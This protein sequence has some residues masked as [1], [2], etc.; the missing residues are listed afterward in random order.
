[1]STETETVQN[2]VENTVTVRPPVSLTPESSSSS[3]T[4]ELSVRA[5]TF[6]SPLSWT[7]ALF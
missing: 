6:I 2:T 1:M 4:A 3:S 5:I 7:G